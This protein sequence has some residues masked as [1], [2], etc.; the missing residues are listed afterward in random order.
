MDNFKI[1]LEELGFPLTDRGSFWQTKAVFRNGDNPTAIIVY[2]DSGV[3]KDF[4]EDTPYLPFEALVYK[5]TGEKDFSKIINNISKAPRVTVKKKGLLQEEK[6]YPESC[7]KRLLP[8]YDFYL[9]EKKGISEQT[10]KDFKCGL[11]TSGK[12]Y[13]R[14]VFPIFRNDGRVHGFSGRLAIEKENFPKW[15]HLG[16]KRTWIYPLFTAPNTKPS[17]ELKKEAIIIESIGDALKLY[18]CGICNTFVSF[19]IS[20]SPTVISRISA[21][22]LS[23]IVLAL[24]DDKD[25]KKNWGKVKSAK[26]AIALAEH[27]DFKKI[28][29][30]PPIQNDFGDMSVEEIKNWELCK[31]NISHQES[32]KIILSILDPKELKG[33]D[34][35]SFKKFKK[36]YNFH[37][38]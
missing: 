14:I 34:L 15:K 23:K 4:V 19:G 13:Q 26:A 24:N 18:D 8:D 5:I 31:N 3:W 33:S 32:C 22:N 36:Q 1:V 7:L 28:F 38:E 20:I 25:S 37:Y 35:S 11:A 9:S 2:K 30:V 10:L 6:S 12:M 27:I 21:M 29:I 16:K 17:I